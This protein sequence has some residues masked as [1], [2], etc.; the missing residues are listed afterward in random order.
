MA[1]RDGAKVSGLIY[2]SQCTFDE[3][4]SIQFSGWGEV[5][6][7]YQT[8]MAV[9]CAGAAK[10]GNP[11][12]SDNDIEQHLA[13]NTLLLFRVSVDDAYVLD[14]NQYLDNSVDAR[15]PIDIKALFAEAGQ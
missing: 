7:D 1:I 9:L 11:P 13:N 8:I 15:E 3:V 6:H 2:N 4:E 12:P 10:E 5:A 14:Q